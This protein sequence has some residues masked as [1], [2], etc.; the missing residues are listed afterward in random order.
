MNLIDICQIDSNL[1]GE[2]DYDFTKISCII[3]TWNGVSDIL[4]V[5]EEIYA[6]LS[7][8]NY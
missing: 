2:L 3:C 8:L 1:K 7:E 5:Y 6:A 4:E